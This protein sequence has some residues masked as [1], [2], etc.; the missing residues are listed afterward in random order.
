MG[1]AADVFRDKAG[2]HRELSPHRISDSTLIT[3]PL[4]NQVATLHLLT[5][6]PSLSLSSLD[7]PSLITKHIPE[8][9]ALK[10]L[11]G[12]E[13]DEEIWEDV[14]AGRGITLRGL[15]SHTSGTSP[16]PNPT[17]RGTNTYRT[18]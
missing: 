7:D 3:L 17:Q 12:Y 11:K 2:H 6:T 14:E 15:L 16:S 1:S 10:I 8:C 5:H 9:A 18:Y 13:G 4:P